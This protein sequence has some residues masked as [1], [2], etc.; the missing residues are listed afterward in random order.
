MTSATPIPGW[1]I[2]ISVSEPDDGEMAARG[3][4]DVHVTH[5]FDEI[6]RQLL[7]AGATLAYG[8]DFR[9]D[10]YTQQLIALLNEYAGG[11]PGKARIRQY[12]AW[13]L[14]E[15]A[16][17]EDRAKLNRVATPVPVPPPVADPPDPGFDRKASPEARALWA[18]SLTRM[19]EAM[20]A[21]M[22]ARVILG[23]RLT[24]HTSRFP[25]VVEEAYLAAREGLPLYV[26]GGFGG[27]ASCLAQVIEGQRPHALT[28]AH[29]RERTPGYPDL[30]D[31]L[32][33]VDWDG[34][35]ATIHRRRVPNGLSDDDDRTLRNTADLDHVVA[36]VVRGLQAL[37]RAG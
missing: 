17:E 30:L 12:L 7:A 27:C 1:E 10:G 23:G 16:S 25:G 3:V 19:R 35:L 20:T 32:G 34:M 24:T 29:Q 31:G 2:A 15:T 36:L 37:A 22:R 28:E 14:W 9:Q 6:A 5:A 18:G 11:S 26:L 21:K 4:S 13:P 8:G 33:G